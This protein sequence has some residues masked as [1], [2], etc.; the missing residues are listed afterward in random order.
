MPRVIHTVTQFRDGDGRT[1]N[2]FSDIDD[3]S[4]PPLFHGH[5]TV[6]LE[7]KGKVIA[8]PSIVFQIPARTVHE[9]F[10]KFDDAARAGAKE[11]SDAESRKLTRARLLGNG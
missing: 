3:P 11:L 7:I 4:A 9:A 5:A 6:P 2:C 10:D 1:I 8:N